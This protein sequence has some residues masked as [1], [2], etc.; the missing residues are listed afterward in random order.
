MTDHAGMTPMIRKIET[1][2]MR[3]DIGCPCFNSKEPLIRCRCVSGEAYFTFLPRYALSA[4]QQD[5]HEQCPLYADGKHRRES[6]GECMCE[7][8]MMK[9]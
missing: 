7:T 9:R 8:G 1:P 6:D 5:K 3:H 2:I 4:G